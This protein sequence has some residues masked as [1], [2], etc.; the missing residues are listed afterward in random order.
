VFNFW[1]ASHN[2]CPHGQ[3]TF[4]HK[5]DH[6]LQD[7]NWGFIIFLNWFVEEEKPNMAFV[8]T[9]GHLLADS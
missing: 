7:T 9:C 1:V 5:Q 3:I 6:I 2:L 8:I 4:N